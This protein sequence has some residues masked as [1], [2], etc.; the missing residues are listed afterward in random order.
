MVWSSAPSWK[1]AVIGKG[2]AIAANRVFSWIKYIQKVAKCMSWMPMCVIISHPTLRWKYLMVFWSRQA[3][4]M[5]S[6][7]DKRRHNAGSRTFT[8]KNQLTRPKSRTSPPRRDE[9]LPQKLLSARLQKTPI[10]VL[11][12][13]LIKT[14]YKLQEVPFSN[15]NS[16]KKRGRQLCVWLLLSCSSRTS[17]ISTQLLRLNSRSHR[18]Y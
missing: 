12:F 3:E 16:S 10:A 13:L 6:L 1:K 18:N 5:S 14:T 8:D 11:T 2:F 7:P 15:R 9:I 4:T 17:T